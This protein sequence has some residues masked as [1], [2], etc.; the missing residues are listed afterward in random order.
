MSIANIFM[1][2]FLYFE[3]KFA[4][5]IWLQS[6]VAWLQFNNISPGN[7][8]SSKFAILSILQWYELDTFNPRYLQFFHK[9]FKHEVLFG[10]TTQYWI[11]HIFI[12]CCLINLFKSFYHDLKIWIWQNIEQF[13]S[14]PTPIGGPWASHWLTKGGHFV[15]QGS[16]KLGYGYSPKIILGYGLQDCT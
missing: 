2:F 3:A 14:R 12:M 15:A 8:I 4:N 1:I 6:L 13:F 5:K 7:Y 11:S 9:T 10:H 16:S